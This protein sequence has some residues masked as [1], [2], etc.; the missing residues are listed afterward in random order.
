MPYHVTWEDQG[1]YVRYSGWTSDE[2][3]ARF[4]R[5]V[6]AD[7]RYGQVHSVLHDFLACEGATFSLPVIEELAATDG[8]A[9]LYNSKIRIAVV[10]GRDDVCAMCRAYLDVGLA[11]YPL[12][13]FPGVDAA[14]AWLK[15]GASD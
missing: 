12:R 7:E 11:D 2:E 1:I 6:Q 9:A 15:E 10:T 5:Q 13:I 8:A 4:A 14:R 3:I